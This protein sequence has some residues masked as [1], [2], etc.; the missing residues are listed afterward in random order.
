MS[1]LAPIEQQAPPSARRPAPSWHVRLASHDDVARVASA[2]RE[3]LVE[4]GGTT[5]PPPTPA[6]EEAARA[7]MDDRQAGALLVA[8]A[9]EEVVGVLGASWQIA[10][11]VPGRYA[12]IQDLWVHPSWR[13]QAIGRDLLAALFELAREQ[14]IARIEVGLPREG[15]PGIDATEAFYRANGFTPLGPRMRRVGP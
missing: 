9:G 12:L 5:M 13:G 10:V 6:L 11:H 8:Q 14:G 15:F 3:L 1:G 2:V 4:L 7:L